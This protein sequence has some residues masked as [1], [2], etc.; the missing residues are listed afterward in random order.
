MKLKKKLNLNYNHIR[1]SPCSEFYSG[2]HIYWDGRVGICGCRDI[3]AKELIIGDARETNINDICFINNREYLL[4]Q[5]MSKPKDVY[6][7]CIH[8]NRPSVFNQI[9]QK[10]NN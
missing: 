6:K 9:S 3:N 7:N 5:F 2:T 10:I 4:E 8:D 1:I